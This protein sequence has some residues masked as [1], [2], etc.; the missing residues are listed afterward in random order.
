M[1]IPS[2]GNHWLPS[3]LNIA[4]LHR[5]LVSTSHFLRIHGYELIQTG[6]DDCYSLSDVL[7]FS[8]YFNSGKRITIS[9]S[10]HE[11]SFLSI[12]LGSLHTGVMNFITSDDIYCL[13][14][15]LTPSMKTC[16]FRGVRGLTDFKCSTVWSHGFNLVTASAFLVGSCNNICPLFVWQFHGL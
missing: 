1:I 3:N 8:K 14:P 2:H 15:T 13:Y 7:S 5:K 12:V 10:P 16:C 6:V 11:D 4:V 9:E